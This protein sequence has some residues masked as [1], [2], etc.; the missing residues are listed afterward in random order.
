M[1]WGNLKD[2]DV[3]KAFQ[4]PEQEEELYIRMENG[5]FYKLLRAY[6]CKH[7]A[8]KFYVLLRKVLIDSGWQPTQYDGGT[9]TYAR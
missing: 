1:Q 2:M 4:I 5:E 8:W 6:G 3:P 7:S 9:M